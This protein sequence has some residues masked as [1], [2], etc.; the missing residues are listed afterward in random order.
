MNKF[1]Q[2]YKAAGFAGKDETKQV[3]TLLYCPGEA[4]VDLTSINA[5]MDEWTVYD[6]KMQ[7]SSK[8]N[9][10]NDVRMKENQSNITSNMIV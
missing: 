8:Y 9:S 6:G 7:Y 3:N 4:G 5:T 1:E 10:T 2:F